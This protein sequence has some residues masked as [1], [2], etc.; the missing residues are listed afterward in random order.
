V[1]D[2]ERIK[3]SFEF[4]DKC[5]RWKAIQELCD[6]CN[7][8][9][10]VKWRDVAGSWQ[11]CAYFVHEDGIDSS[12]AGLDIPEA[13]TITDP[14]SYLMS[15]ITV[16]DSPEHQYN[17]VLMTGYDAATSTYFY[18]TA[19][20][21]EVTAGTEI[22]IE[23]VHA[24]ASLHSQLRTNLKAQELLEFFQESAKVYVA[25]FKRRMD[26]E[27]YQK[28][29]FS[30]YNKIDADEMR[31]TRIVYSRSAANDTVEIEFSKDQAIQQLRR[32]ARAVNPDY[33][34]GTQDIISADL[35]YTG[36]ID[37]FDIPRASG[38]AEDDLW[39]VVGASTE[40]IDTMPICLNGEPLTR[41]RYIRGSLGE[42][43]S[44][45]GSDSAG[46]AFAE[47]MRWNR[48]SSEAGLDQYIEILEPLFINN[49]PLEP[50]L[51]FDIDAFKKTYISAYT[52]TSLKVMEFRVGNSLMLRSLKVMEFRVGNSL[53][54]RLNDYASTTSPN[55]ISCYVNVLMNHDLTM[56][57][58]LKG[59]GNMDLKFWD[60]ATGTKTLQELAS[61]G[62]NA[63]TVDGWNVYGIYSSKRSVPE[64]W[65]YWWWWDIPFEGSVISVIPAVHIYLGGETGWYPGIT[66][67]VL[68][69]DFGSKGV[70]IMV[71][72]GSEDR[73]DMSVEALVMWY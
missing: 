45:W 39:Q 52:G 25:K 43:L 26:L 71:H 10:V 46:V 23:Y 49:D 55:L 66:V 35:S 40:L 73:L 54:L 6:Y 16:K 9:F 62:K 61:G 18:A 70:Y 8:V 47:F 20:T 22:P 14:D 24:D 1:T 69:Q 5:T 4:G 57:G 48:S 36:L 31:I 2:W 41:T 21:Q 51:Y 42:D 30:G 56:V 44:L 37:V 65:C 15:G 63:D 33:V 28:I 38:T 13:V 27:L 29:T 34:T 12:T 3:K 50:K 17:R 67:S 32:L 58:K 11:P 60:N 64:D 72:N 53:M 68:E 19:Q 7:F 59:D